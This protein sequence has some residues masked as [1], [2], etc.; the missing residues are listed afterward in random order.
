MRKSAA[1]GRSIVVVIVF[2]TLFLV[3][4]DAVIAK[5]FDG[6]PFDAEPLVFRFFGFQVDVQTLWPPADF[7]I[8]S[9]IGIVLVALGSVIL[10]MLGNLRLLNPEYLDL[11]VYLKEGPLDVCTIIALVPAHNEGRNLP[12]TLPALMQQTRP[13]DR[14]IVVADNCSDDTVEVARSL[15]AEVF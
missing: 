6:D 4:L 15:G 11:D 10:E 13:P 5:Y 2:A 9:V 3:T 14:I 12:V 8:F 7:L 1:I